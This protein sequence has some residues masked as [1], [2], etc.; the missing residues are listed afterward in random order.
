MALSRLSKTGALLSSGSDLKT[1]L[2]MHLT[3]SAFF[4]GPERLMLGLS[5]SLG[6]A[7]RTLF[8]LFA[9]NGKSEAFLQ[10]LLRHGQAATL[11]SN[12]TPHLVAM[13]CEL[14]GR[15]KASGADVLCCH[16]YKADVVGLLAARRVGVPVIAMSHGWTAESWKV[17]VY[18]A[19][20][21][22]CLRR[23]DRVICVSEGQADR[24]RRC[25]VRP[26]RV[27]VI[28]N[29]VRAD[30][31]DHTEPSDRRVLEAMFP[32]VP[33]RI[34]G[35]AG[36]LSPEKGFGILV[37]AAAIVSRSDPGA[38]FIH[39]GDGPLRKTIEK[40]IRELGLEERFILAGLRNDLDRFLPHWDLSVLPSF[41]EG[42][43]TVVL[44]S[45][46]AGVPVVAT[47]VGGTPEAVADGVDGYLVPPG[48]PAALAERIIDVLKEDSKR[49]EMGRLG[50][51]RIG[52]EFTFDAQ[53]MRF[54]Q[55]CADVANR[56]RARHSLSSRLANL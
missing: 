7:W 14:T 9:D 19:L 33:E 53:A 16:G 29:A 26:E 47:A 2:A 45:Y 23:M 31:F 3:T 13:V 50:R 27:S 44:E 49:R 15:L 17:S 20:D 34:V 42:L 4:G 5:Q 55:L 28:R 8:C 40:R 43:P 1:M 35:S 48:S 10:Q 30:R 11:L 21:R 41:T 25:G 22:A 51:E 24:V 56:S 18:E 36:R 38:G 54:Q 6:P 46:A 52:V 39:F 37:E 32:R 12:D